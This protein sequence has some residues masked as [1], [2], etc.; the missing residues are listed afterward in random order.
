MTNSGFYVSF[1]VFKTIFAIFAMFWVLHTHVMQ[2]NVTDT[3]A[4]FRSKILQNA[5]IHNFL[6]I[7][8]NCQKSPKSG[9]KIVTLCD[10]VALPDGQ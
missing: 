9:Y 7:A 8:K 3:S 5:K 10:F 1:E 2:Q 6:K 4:D